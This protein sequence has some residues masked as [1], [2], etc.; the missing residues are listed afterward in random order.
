M[1]RLLS[2]LLIVCLFFPLTGQAAPPEL[3]GLEPYVK[4]LMTLSHVP[5]VAVAVVQ[6][7]KLVLSEGFGVRKV[8][9]DAPVNGDTVFAIGSMTKNFT[10]TALGLLVD[11]GKLS[12]DKPLTRYHAKLRFSDPY[13]F[14]TL[15]LRDALSHRTGLQRADLI[16][17]SRPGASRDEMIAA[18]ENIPR[19][20]PYRAS[21]LYNNFM[22]VAAGE[23]VPAVTGQSW[24]KFLRERLLKPLDMKRTNTNVTAL[25]NMKNVATPHYLTS[26][27]A[28]AT[29]Y[30]DLA[31]VGPAGSINSSVNDMAQWCR[32]QLGDGK[33]GGQQLVPGEVLQ[34]IRKPHNFLELETQ[35][36]IG[37]LHK[38]YT[39]GLERMN[40][41]DGHVLYTHGGAIQG[42]ASTIAFVP[43][44]QVCV[45][46]LTNG[47]TGSGVRKYVSDW[48]LDRLLDLSP[49]NSIEDFTADLK[50]RRARQ[51]EARTLHDSSHDISIKPNIALSSLVGVYRNDI[52]GELTIENQDGEIHARY[53]KAF[54]AVLKPHRGN[55]FDLIF[56]DP[57]RNA[58]APAPFS[59]SVIPD[60]T[61]APGSLLFETPT[62]GQEG[63]RFVAQSENTRP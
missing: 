34:E 22:Y 29:D 45:V 36:H 30:Y 28:I 21:Y 62:P 10:A 17:F 1:R 9:S 52:F 56:A 51:D 61:G 35:G 49:T 6:E 26:E 20:Q 63:I 32:L 23:M 44:A 54:A 46:V 16:W 55:T 57:V 43:D 53:G 58:V 25:E 39:L 2:Q 38:S 41:G 59:V 7:D 14:T 47:Q 13:L 11:D 40:Y 12:W 18:I 27:A 4:K 31:H 24:D 37:T 50:T 3:E 60:K 33:L 42:M 5:G 15:N 8:G 19:V 48:I